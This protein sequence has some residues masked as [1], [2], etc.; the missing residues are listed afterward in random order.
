MFLCRTKQM[1]LAEGIFINTFMELDG[2]AITALEVETKNLPLYTIGPIIQSGSSNPVEGSDC[3]RWLN[4]QPSGSVLFV[5]F[6]SGGTL[7][8]DQ[9]NELAFGL[10]LSK[11]K[12]LWVHYNKL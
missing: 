6:G 5:C 10:E 12:F 9:M 2:N 11:Q 3:L 1:R 4:N 8:Y 7:S